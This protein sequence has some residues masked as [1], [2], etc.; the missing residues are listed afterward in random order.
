MSGAGEPSEARVPWFARLLR[1]ASLDAVAPVRRERLVMAC[2][3]ALLLPAIVLMGVPANVALGD[4]PMAVGT[5]LL[6][7]LT[8]AT[9]VLVAA[10][11]FDA[12]RLVLVLGGPLALMGPAVLAGGVVVA[13]LTALPYAVLTMSPMPALVFAPEEGRLRSACNAYFAVVLLGHDLLL[14]RLSELPAPPLNVKLAQ[15][16]LWLIMV[17]TLHVVSGAL[18]AKRRADPVDGPGAD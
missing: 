6:L 15:L 11:R 14:A 8:V 9:P 5:T 16:V 10:G 2:R 17:L 18:A 12:G 1:P 4:A 3:I 7:V 13:N